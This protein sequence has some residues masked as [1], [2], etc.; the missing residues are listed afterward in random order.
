MAL[1]TTITVGRLLARNELINTAKLNAMVRGIVINISGSV[2]PSDL[3]P[4]A[5]T[6]IATSVDAFWYAL[7]T[8][9]GVVYGATYAPPVTVYKDGMWFKFNADLA[10]QPAAK[11]NAGGGA[12]PLLYSGQPIGAGDI[13]AGADVIVSYNST[14]AAFEIMSPIGTRPVT[15]D[16]QYANAQAGGIRG[17][18]PRPSASATRLFLRDDG[19]TDLT[20]QVTAIV[21][22]QSTI[23]PTLAQFLLG[24][25]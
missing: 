14:L 5:V 1:T 24:Q 8:S 11:F 2:G 13:P 3:A 4:G 25:H 10:S 18:V 20:A 9:A 17:L 21:A 23:A 19:W 12:L 6:A 22:A 15:A 7:A 16:F